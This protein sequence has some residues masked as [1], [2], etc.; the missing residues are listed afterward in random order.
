MN[1][2]Y[3]VG[4]STRTLD[5]FLTLLE[6]HGIEGLVDVR[7]FPSSWRHPWFN[8]GSLEAALGERG[9]VYEHEPDLGGRR[10]ASPDSPNDAW[11]NA[12][13]RGYA[14]H[15]ATE[16]FRS[17]LHRV[18]SRAAQ[19][20]T[21]IL[22]AEAVPWRCHRNLIADAAVAAGMEVVH[23]LGPASTSAHAL[24]PAVRIE[25]DGRITYPQEGNLRLDLR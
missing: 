14:D 12:S 25:A 9:V 24:N 15:M 22:C 19:R 13:F 23:I 6:E 21:V 11:R 17:A 1:T 7:R 16:A 18:L 3:T 2:L 4:H 5:A 20:P 10:E 8:G